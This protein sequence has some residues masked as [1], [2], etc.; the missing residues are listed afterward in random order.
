MHVINLIS[1][2]VLFFSHMTPAKYVVP[3]D[4]NVVRGFPEACAT[5]SDRVPM[6]GHMIRV[7]FIGNSP[8]GWG[9]FFP[10]E[11]EQDQL[12]MIEIADNAGMIAQNPAD[13]LYDLIRTQTPES[14]Y[15]T[16]Q[17]LVGDPTRGPTV[18]C[19]SRAAIINNYQPQDFGDQYNWLDRDSLRQW[20][21]Y[22][23]YKRWDWQRFWADDI[24]S[25]RS[26]Y[27]GHEQEPQ[28]DRGRD[29]GYYDDSDKYRRR[30]W[31]RRGHHRWRSQRKNHRDQKWYKNHK[32]FGRQRGDGAD[33]DYDGDGKIDRRQQ[34]W[35]H[36]RRSDE[37][38]DDDEVLKRGDRH[39]GQQRQVDKKNDD[40]DDVS[41]KSLKNIKRGWRK[42]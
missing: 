34:G 28:Y 40:Q 19:V 13:N 41:A 24:S 42:R 15:V 12:Q 7:G 39:S 21:T 17:I 8:D 37:N 30:P 29:E 35:S 3:S 16:A 2:I 23:Q 9:F 18:T 32:T 5:A 1:I 36:R 33:D 20:L 27:L 4:S 25:I 14:S 26:R 31:H 38:V 10:D 22:K 11:R 6:A